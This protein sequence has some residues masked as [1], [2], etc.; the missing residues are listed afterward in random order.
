M[1]WQFYPA[2]EAFKRF[3]PGWDRLNK[4]LY[5]VHPLSDSGFVLPL[6]Q[7]FGGPNLV[8]AV[9]GGPESPDAMALIEKRNPLQWSS[10]LPGQAQI[11]PVLFR[12][13]SQ[14]LDMLK[15]LPAYP[16]TLD[17]LAQDPLFSH[18]LCDQTNVHISTMDHAVTMNIVCKGD[19]ETYWRNRPKN[20][21]KNI[22][23]YFNRLDSEGISYS[24]GAFNEETELIPALDRY[25]VLESKGWKAKAGT[26]IHPNNI[27]GHFYSDVLSSF[28]KNSRAEK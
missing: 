11:S 6:V 15:A 19:F 4:H 22:S 10:F 20:L 17:I 13:R 16:L 14:V 24:F 21:R 1:N 2:K 26:A 23:R 18:L 25:G 7:Y 28:A 3:C 27:Q 9:S 12:D 8:L 5:Q